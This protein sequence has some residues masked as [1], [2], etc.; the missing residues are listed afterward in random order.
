MNQF[1]FFK[2]YKNFASKIR[3]ITSDTLLRELKSTSSAEIKKTLML[4][5]VEDL[6]SSTEDLAMW[7]ITIHSRNDGNKKFRD[8]WERLLFTQ[9]N[10]E[11]SRK[12][13][14]DYSRI[15]TINGFL[16][17]MNFPTIKQLKEK[18]RTEEKMVN[19]AVEAIIHTIETALKTRVDEDRIVERFQNKIKHGMMVYSDIDTSNSWVRDFSVKQTKKNGRIVKKNRNFEI[20]IDLG[21]AERIVGTIKANAQGI[22]ALIN[23]LLIDYEYRIESRKIKMWEKN[24][25][26]CLNEI[27]KALG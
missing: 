17:K 6:V 2:N 11:Q 10:Q 24:R 13:L 12:I 16:K 18:L 9:V 26:K 20:P 27:K 23:L 3:Y 14:S 4:R 7:L 8:E 25:E 21:K 22:E 19:D 5:I 1:E 15:K